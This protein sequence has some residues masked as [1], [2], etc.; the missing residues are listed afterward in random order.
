[1]VDYPRI[2]IYQKLS[3]KTLFILAGRE[4]VKLVCSL[5]FFEQI[6]YYSD[7][8]F[9][10]ELGDINST[11]MNLF[12][13]HTSTILSF[14]SNFD[15]GK[16]ENDFNRSNIVSENENRSYKIS[17]LDPMNSN[18]VFV[19]FSCDIK[20]SLRY[21]VRAFLNENLIK[22]KACKSID[23]NI[24]DLISYIDL[25]NKKCVSSKEICTFRDNN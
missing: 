5:K 9:R 24:E 2:H 10:S 3:N 25:L 15:I 1:M 19:L 16:G 14:L 4:R 20:S 7:I 13:S 11:K 21:I 17:K 22:L 6:T 8:F 23:C 12:F 18:I